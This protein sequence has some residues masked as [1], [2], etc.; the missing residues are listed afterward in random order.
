MKLF[1][2]FAI[3]SFVNISSKALIENIFMPLIIHTVYIYELTNKFRTVV[4][5][6]L[7]S[8]NG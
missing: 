4:T 2:L 7:F 6:P 3:A 1:L 8:A 5:G